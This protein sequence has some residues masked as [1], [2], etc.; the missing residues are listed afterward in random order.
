MVYMFGASAMSMAGMG[1][2]PAAGWLGGGLAPAVLT[3]TL[4]AYFACCASW[5][6]P[7]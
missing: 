4:A 6:R 3:W 1:G 2:V 7:G 5:S